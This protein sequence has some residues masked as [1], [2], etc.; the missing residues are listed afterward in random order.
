[1][2]PD[3]ILVNITL[4]CVRGEDSSCIRFQLT[5][6]P[7]HVTSSTDSSRA[8][9]PTT[10][11]FLPRTK[12]CETGET[13]SWA[14]QEGVCDPAAAFSNHLAENAPRE[15]QALFS[16]RRNNGAAL[17]LTRS[18]FL[19]RL[20]VAAEAA[21]QTVHL[22]GHRLRIGLALEYLL[23]GTPFGVVRAMGRW[24]SDAFILYLRRHA[25]IPFLISSCALHMFPS[26]SGANPKSAAYPAGP[27]AY[28]PVC[29]AVACPLMLSPMR[30]RR[31][32]VSLAPLLLLGCSTSHN[33]SWDS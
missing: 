25:D 26:K 2:L 1:M 28:P 7:S 8:N 6:H 29:H 11:F 14:P 21:G 22:R 17:P 20:Q 33:T 31:L 12:C 23:R 9:L 5:R 16:W 32:T 19:K 13:V 3:Y 24:A 27:R 4:R 15:K 10:S 30:W 18:V